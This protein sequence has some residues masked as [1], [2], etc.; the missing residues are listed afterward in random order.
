M[1]KLL[2]LPTMLYCSSAALAQ[3]SNCSALQTENAALK[4]KLVA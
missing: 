3:T 2:L 4:D 1:K